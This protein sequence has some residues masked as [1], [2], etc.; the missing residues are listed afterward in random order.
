MNSYDKNC[1]QTNVTPVCRTCKKI[2]KLA[3]CTIDANPEILS[4]ELTK[5]GA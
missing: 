5:N 3:G 1:E 2:G 4:S